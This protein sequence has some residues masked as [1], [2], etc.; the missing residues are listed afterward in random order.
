MRG[1]IQSS[2]FYTLV[3]ENTKEA[4][5]SSRRQQCL[6]DQGYVYSVVR[7]PPPVQPPPPP[8]SSD[9]KKKTAAAQPQSTKKTKKKNTLRQRLMKHKSLCL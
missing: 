5:D 4:L 3:S 6:K 2:I 9:A 1:Q 7:Q 8:C